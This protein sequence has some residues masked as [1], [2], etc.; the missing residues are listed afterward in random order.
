ML[1]MAETLI[2]LGPALSPAPGLRGFYVRAGMSLFSTPLPA[3]MLSRS[4]A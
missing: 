2:G 1:G 3:A 4:G